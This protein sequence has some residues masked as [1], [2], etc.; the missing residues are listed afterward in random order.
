MARSE[1]IPHVSQ[2]P[3]PITSGVPDE[4]A[5]PLNSPFLAVIE[6]YVLSHPALLD[7]YFKY[8]KTVKRTLQDQKHGCDQNQ[9]GRY[10]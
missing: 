3:V 1:I 8:L 4:S 7:I 6:P 2:T 9:M 5:V 10:S